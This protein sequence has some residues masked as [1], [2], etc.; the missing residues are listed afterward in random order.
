MAY[1]VFMEGREVEL[2]P[3]KDA[4]L[5]RDSLGSKD[6][7]CSRRQ[8]VVSFLPPTASPSDPHF[9]LVAVSPSSS[10]TAASVNQPNW[11]TYMNGCAA[12]DQQDIYSKTGSSRTTADG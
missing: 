1:V 12:R 7:R 8:L 4:V 6:K 5:G 3:E 11:L 10:K 9:A 2:V